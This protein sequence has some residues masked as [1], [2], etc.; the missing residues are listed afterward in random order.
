MKVNSMNKV[1][2][3][4]SYGVDFRTQRIRTDPGEPDA[5]TGQAEPVT[6]PEGRSRRSRRKGFQYSSA[7]I[8]HNALYGAGTAGVMLVP[9]YLLD[10]SY[11]GIVLGI[12]AVSL[13]GFFVI[14][15]LGVFQNYL[16]FGRQTQNNHYR[17]H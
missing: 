5:R 10:T 9:Y 17:R 7:P 13:G 12:T 14:S 3:Q 11:L 15:V 4:A 8:W 6:G 1:K 16:P 2:K